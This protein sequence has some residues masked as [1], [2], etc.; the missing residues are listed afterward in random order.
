MHAWG[1]GRTSDAFTRCRAASYRAARDRRTR[2]RRSV[3]G[4]QRQ[5]RPA[6]QHRGDS[7]SSESPAAVSWRDPRGRVPASIG[8]LG[9]AAVLRSQLFRI[10]VVFGASKPSEIHA[11]VL[12]LS[13]AASLPHISAERTPRR[14]CLL[15]QA[16]ARTSG[17][18][19][20]SAC[21]VYRGHG[22]LQSSA[23]S[24]SHRLRIGARSALESS[25]RSPDVPRAALLFRLAIASEGITALLLLWAASCLGS[26]TLSASGFPIAFLR[27]APCFLAGVV[28]YRMQ[29][30]Q[31]DSGRLRLGR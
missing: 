26:I 21:T 12:R 1:L 8:S 9:R 4:R 23:D 3:L 27:Y 7:C 22:R 6:A 18:P 10:D 20:I 14:G 29:S 15:V 11:P 13:A 25:V 17:V 16:A 19:S 24:K 5:P 2:G 31:Y 28:G 30:D